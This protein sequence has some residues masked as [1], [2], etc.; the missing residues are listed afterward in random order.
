MAKKS[1]ICLVDS[2]SFVPLQCEGGY[3][4]SETHLRSNQAIFSLVFFIGVRRTKDDEP[5]EHCH[6][7][8]CVPEGGEVLCTFAMMFL[9]KG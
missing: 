1:A 7:Q 2:G 8:P 9:G 4:P 5:T 6:A 3:K